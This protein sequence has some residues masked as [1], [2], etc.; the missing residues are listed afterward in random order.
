MQVQD[1]LSDC[2]LQIVG[3]N[4]GEELYTYSKMANLRIQWS[5]SEQ[6]AAS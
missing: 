3:Y 2:G 4:C 6:T 1:A 5:S